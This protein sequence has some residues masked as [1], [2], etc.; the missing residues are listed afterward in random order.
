MPFKECIMSKLERK[1]ISCPYCKR[2]IYETAVACPFCGHIDQAD[3]ATK[4]EMIAKEFKEV[5]ND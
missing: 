5:N 4:Q 3:E 1:K 2:E